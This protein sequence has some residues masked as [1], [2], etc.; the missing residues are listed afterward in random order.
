MR[1]VA[2]VTGASS[3]IGEAFAEALRQVIPAASKDD[4]R[5]ILTGV[6]LAATEKG[7]RLVATDSYRLAV[8]D[9]PGVGLLSEGQKVLVSAK[10]LNEVQ[11][12]FGQGTITVTL[13]YPSVLPPGTR[14]WKQVGGT[15]VD[16]TNKVTISG[17]SVILTGKILQFRGLTE[18]QPDFSLVQVVAT[19]R[20]VPEPLVLNCAQVNATF[21]PDY[22]E[23]NE[24]RL[25]R[26]NGVTD[27]SASKARRVKLN[28]SDCPS[29]NA[30]TVVS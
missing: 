30:D 18:I 5:P 21:K 13:K 1:R 9:L 28:G 16:W 11:R 23:P 3:G 29:A 6:L 27:A 8:R 7:L 14:Y 10:G 24:G 4:A 20:P 25:V 17:D 19:G 12:V 15:W 26:V 2:L 22:T